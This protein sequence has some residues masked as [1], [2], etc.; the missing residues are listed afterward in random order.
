MPWDWCVITEENPT[1]IRLD[2]GTSFADQSPIAS[3]YE[4][5]VTDEFL[6]QQ[7]LFAR[8]GQHTKIRKPSIK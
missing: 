8:C 2:A 6:R 7:G 1:S 4:T 3:V 5:N